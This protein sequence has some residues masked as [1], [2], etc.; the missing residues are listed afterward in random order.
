MPT[1]LPTFGGVDFLSLLKTTKR[2]NGQLRSKLLRNWAEAVRP[3]KHRS[4]RS[5][6]PGLWEVGPSFCRPQQR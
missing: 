6:R 5:E 4:K 3:R 2:G 1:P